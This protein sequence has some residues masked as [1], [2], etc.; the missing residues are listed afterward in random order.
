MNIPQVSPDQV[1]ESITSRNSDIV[2][3]DVRTP[4]EYE[5][6][7]IQGSINLPIN[8]IEARIEQI[9]PDKITT[10]YVYCVSASRSDQGV[11]KLLLLGYTNSFSMTNGLLMW[12]Y[13]KY[14][15]V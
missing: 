6:G 4:Q 3:L 7:K 13:K 11:Q 12:R 10:I 5:K 14:P 8:E 15:L 1:Y 9:V 2:I